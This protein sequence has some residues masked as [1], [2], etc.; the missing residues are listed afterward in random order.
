MNTKNIKPEKL[1]DTDEKI[2]SEE[3]ES[4]RNQM[5]E[6]QL[7][8]DILKETINVL[9]KDQGVNH[10]GFLAICQRLQ[11]DALV[12]FCDVCR[13]LQHIPFEL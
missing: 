11:I 4:L 13:L 3:V 1:P 12:L 2:S 6:L 5:Y 7:E 9:K 8:V 10:C